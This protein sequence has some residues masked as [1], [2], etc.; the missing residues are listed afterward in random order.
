LQRLVSLLVQRE[1]CVGDQAAALEA[2]QPVVSHPLRDLRRMDWVRNRQ[3]GHHVFYS[4]DDELVR[5]LYY[6]VLAHIGQG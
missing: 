6:Q 1:F 5:D 4:Q 2:G 3:E